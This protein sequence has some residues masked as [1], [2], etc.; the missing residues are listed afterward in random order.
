MMSSE[1][2]IIRYD[3]PIL[4]DHQMDISDLAPA[5][6]GIS[7]LCKITN[8]RFNED[9]S[10]IK[11][12]M[13]ADI[14]QKCIQLDLQVILTIWDAIKDIINNDEVRS[15]KDLLEWIGILSSPV[16]AVFGAI[17]L[18]KV[19]NGK[20][21][22]SAELVVKDNRNVMQISIEGDSNNI[23]AYPQA[24]ELLHDESAISNIKKIVTP[25]TKDGYDKLEFVST[26]E[27]IER[28]TKE[29]ASIIVNFSS[30][31]IESRTAESQIINAW[32]S[33]YSP[34]YD[35][36]APKWRFRYGESTEYMDISETSIATEAFERGGALIN[37]TY[38]V[39]LEIRQEFNPGGKITTNFKIKEVL[40]FKAAEIK[41][42]GK[43]FGNNSSVGNSEKR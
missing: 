22:N 2:I 8:K 11:V 35:A 17:K 12:L 24:W 16:V 37:D 29:D 32:V 19:I 43:L 30:S 41:T 33:V 36:N 1:K 18:C 40:D 20:E 34:V 5:L 15:A 9:K 3:G 26:E 23:Y 10:S 28:I 14:E 25:V 21:I 42:Q 4:E 7:E 39:R 38:Y 13:K 27:R 31:S 6:L